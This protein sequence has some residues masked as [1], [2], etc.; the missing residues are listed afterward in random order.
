[1]GTIDLE[2]GMRFL[3]SR[4]TALAGALALLLL[5][6]GVAAW[7]LSGP[8][9]AERQVVYAVPPGTAARLAA[10]ESVEVLPSTI[11]LTLNQRDIL[12]IR[13][14]DT[15]PVQIGPFK[16]EP[17]QRFVQQYYNR[18]TYDLVCSIHASQRLRIVVN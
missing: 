7:W 16:I 6:S 17:G 8:S 2:A 3:I 11:E 15:Q 5:A 14:D 4:R 18:G 1:M 10:G 9:E 13:N 12:I